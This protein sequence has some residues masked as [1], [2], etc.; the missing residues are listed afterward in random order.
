[1]LIAK[2]SRWPWRRRESVR[3][4]SNCSGRQLKETT[5]QV[6]SLNRLTP[7]YV[8]ADNPLKDIGLQS[9]KITH[10]I[11]VFDLSPMIK[12]GIPQS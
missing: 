5:R 12:A 3:K 10:V 1:M 8:K 9:G 6:M 4:H 11:S 2:T 7:R